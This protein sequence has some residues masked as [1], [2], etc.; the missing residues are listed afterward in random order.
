MV[1][2]ALCL[3]VFVGVSGAQAATLFQPLTGISIVLDPGHGGAD[4]GAIGPKGLRESATN[5]RVARYL[6]LLLEADGARVVLTRTADTFLSLP[7]RVE[8]AKQEHPDLFV[9]IHHNASLKPGAPN[10]G[11]I[12]FNALDQGI[13]LNVSDR[14]QGRLQRSSIGTGTTVIPGG[15]Y[16]LR[17]N[18]IPA[19]LTEAAYI[20]VPEI[21]KKLRSGRALVDEA[22]AFHLAIREAFSLPP[23]RME[24]IGA[25]PTVIS[26][27][28]FQLL[29]SASRP[30]AK[31]ETRMEP[32]FRAGFSLDMIPAFGHLYT[33]SNTQPVNSGEYQLQITGRSVDGGISTMMRVPLS[34][35]L[36][37]ESAVILP[38][39][40]YIPEGFVGSFPLTIQMLDS[41]ERPNQRP[42]S[43]SVVCSGMRY[44]STTRADGRAGIVVP[45]NGS[46]RSSIVVEVSAEGRKVGTMPLAVKPADETFIL[47]RVGSSHTGSH[48]CRCRESPECDDES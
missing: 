26:T 34:V 20:S 15:F 13:P 28:Y 27:P 5:L 6:A 37:V 48:D 3:A 45:L 9:S 16:V 10:K 11:E 32:A 40:P 30:V 7:A 42:V 22:R 19:V 36:P 31:L 25:K 2:L 8:M 38:V 47:G 43:F 4:P 14:M 29:L 24:V 44:A 39:A 35:R 33:L 18:E 1:S 41:L 46:E 23:L 17:E 12:Y 21:E